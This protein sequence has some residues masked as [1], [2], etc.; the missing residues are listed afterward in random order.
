MNM[1][2]L[3]VITTCF[4][5]DFDDTLVVTD[6]RIKIYKNKT[7]LKA[8]TPKEFNGYKL[9]KGEVYDFRDF[10]DREHILNA[11]KYKMWPTLERINKAVKEGKPAF[12]YILTARGNVVKAYIYEFLKRNG[13]E[14]DM[15]RILTVGDHHPQSSVSVE[16]HQALTKLVGEYNKVFF[17]DDDT[18]NI[19]LARTVQGVIPMLVETLK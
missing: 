12:I 6:A 7:F 4:V 18:K 11:E 16:K 5:F 17:F 1:R 14:I 8:L 2:A 3:P 10:D 19:E 13:V 9:Q 15:H